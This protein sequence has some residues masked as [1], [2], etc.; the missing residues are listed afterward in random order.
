[1]K[2]L[3]FVETLKVTFQK[4]SGNEKIIKSVYFNSKAETI[5]N[6]TQIELALKVSKQQILLNIF[7]WISEGSCW[8]IQSIDN[9]HFNIVK[10]QPIKGSS[11]IKLPQELQHS[12]KRLI[13][14]NDN[15]CFRWC[16]ICHLNQQNKVLQR[17]KKSDSAFIKNLNYHGI[18]FTVTIKQINKIEK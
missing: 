14:N 1:M 7:Q 3:K 2:G 15:E 4:K 8:V 11:Y 6:K 9:H 13:Q 18:E 17:I 5:I 10:Y 12:A 16:H